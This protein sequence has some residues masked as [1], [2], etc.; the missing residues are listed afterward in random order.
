MT[1]FSAETFSSNGKILLTGE[2]L[3]LKGAKALALPL[4]LQQS[5]KV[6]GESAYG[7][8]LLNWQAHTPTEPWM[9][10]LF[11]LPSLDVIYSNKREASPK[12]QAILLTLKQLN[13]N[14]FDGSLS[15]NIQTRL[16]FEPHWGLGSSS[17]LIANLARWANVDPYE[18]LRLSIGGSGY[19]IACATAHYPIFYELKDYRPIAKRANF[20]PPFA[21]KLYFVYRGQKK[22]SLEGIRTFTHQHEHSALSA[23]ISRV[24]QIS[25]EAAQCTSFQSFCALM[26]EHEQIIGTLLQASPLKASYPD[27]DGHLKNLGAWGGDFMLAISDMEADEVVRYFNKKGLNVLF[28]YGRIIRQS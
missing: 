16:D 26:D 27:F 17:T 2:Y 18:L 25:L 12:L 11:E 13:P 20:K 19:D 6:S 3:V 4:V 14:L 23:E 1:L 9:K 22:D 8:A 10:V 7:H 24:S 21:D 5:L 15:W 28:P